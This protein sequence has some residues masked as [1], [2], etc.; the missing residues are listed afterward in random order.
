MNDYAVVLNAGS[1]SLK[2]C[3]YQRPANEAWRLEARGQIEGIGTSPR[4]SVEEWRRRTSGRRSARQRGGAR[5][6]RCARCARRLAPLDLRRRPRARRRPPRGARRAAVHRSHHR[7]APGARRAQNARAARAASSAAQPRG[8][9][10]GHR[11]AAGRSSGRLLRHELSPR[12]AGRRRSR[13]AAARHLRRAA[14]SATAS[15]ASRTSTSRRCFPTWLPTSR[16][17]A[18]SSRTW[19]AAPASARCGTGRASTARSGSRRSTGSA[20]ARVLARSI[21]AWSST[22]F[23]TSGSRPRTWRPSSTRS[24]ACSASPGRATTCATFWPAANRRARLAVDY[25]VYRAAKEIG[26]LAAVLGG[27]DALVFTAGIGEN[28]AEIRSR[29]CAASAW[30]GIDMDPDANRARA[31]A[32]LPIGK[33]RLGLGDPDQRGTDHRAPHR[34]RCWGLASSGHPSRRR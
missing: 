14:C 11:A 9:R 12:A 10:R 32:D 6:P 24:R 33:P 21:P 3:V 28:S 19:E 31:P 4:F 5:R 25:F 15:T 20:W 2:F 27:I 16:T 30:L 8:D 17:D 34:Q 1:S 18:S 7:H 13:S 29:I 26:A 22:S 23:R